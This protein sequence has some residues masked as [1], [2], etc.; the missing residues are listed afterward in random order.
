[1]NHPN[2]QPVTPQ[3]LMR[4]LSEDCE[5]HAQAAREKL[6]EVIE[7]FHAGDPLGAIGAFEGTTEM[8][9]YMDAIVKRLAAIAS[10]S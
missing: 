6:R 8:V 9:V 10:K 3:S 1:M 7:R 4:V 5:H 2:Q